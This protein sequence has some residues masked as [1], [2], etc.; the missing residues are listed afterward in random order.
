V[1]GSDRVVRWGI[2]G[3]ANIARA[4]FLPALA[5]AGRGEPV[6]VGGRQLARATDYAAEHG[7][8]RGVG[9]Y[10]ALLDDPDIDAVYLAL[11]NALHAEWAV[12]TLEAG[13]ALLC[14]KPLTISV[15]DTAAVLDVAARS[16]PPLWEA[17][18]FPFQAQH[19]RLLQ[20]IA[21]GAIGEVREVVGSFHFQ[22]THKDN[23]RFSQELGGGSLLDVGCY[24]VRLAAEI[25]GV[26]PYAGSAEGD[27]VDGVDVDA[28]GVLVYP[29]GSRLLLTCGFRRSYDAFTRI[30]GTDGVIHLTNAYHPGPSDTVEVVRAGGEPVIERPTTDRHSFTAAL[31]HIHAVLLDGEPPR[32]LATDVSL[33]SARALER[34]IQSLA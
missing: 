20:L 18:V 6:A 27:L 17:F 29:G 10:Q 12:R 28:A 16:A 8:G 1:S 32:Q 14:E 13:K 7:V 25:F 34:L 23:I 2:L 19:A 30:L 5:E 24:P 15:A 21:D 22:L 3:T 9:G 11:P 4:Q 31:R 26:E 33:P